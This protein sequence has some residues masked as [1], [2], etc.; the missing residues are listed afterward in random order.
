MKTASY[1]PDD[2]IITEGEIG[3]K[4]YIV[5]KGEVS[6]SKGQ[7]TQLLKGKIT[8]KHLCDLYPGD[9]FGELALTQDVP[10]SVTVV[11]KTHCKLITL[12]Q[13]SYLNVIKN[14]RNYQIEGI[15]DYLYHLPLFHYVERPLLL[16]LAKRV[17]YK[18]F[19]TNTLILRQED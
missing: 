14:L 2:V 10:R 8:Q 11:A 15:A 16:E 9:S 4:F 17:E 19:T 7:K 1:K 5:F 12:D 13:E 18:K 3:D 6:I